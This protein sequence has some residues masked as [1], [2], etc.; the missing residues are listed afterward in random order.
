MIYTEAS[1]SA[2][3]FYCLKKCSIFGV[4]SILAIVCTAIVWVTEEAV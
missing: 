2:N 1:E 4:S 3:M